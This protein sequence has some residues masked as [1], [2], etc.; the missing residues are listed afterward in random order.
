MEFHLDNV[1]LHDN[2]L[3]VIRKAT[4]SSTI[5]LDSYLEPVFDRRLLLRCHD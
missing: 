2:P 5:A 1:V 3:Q 4:K